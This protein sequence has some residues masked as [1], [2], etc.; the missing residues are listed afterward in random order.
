MGDEAGLE[1]LARGGA[2]GALT[3]WA[4]VFAIGPGRSSVR[5][6]AALLALAVI[7]FVLNENHTLAKNVG[8]IGRPLFVLSVAAVGYL[9]FLVRTLFD[10]RV[11]TFATTAPIAALTVSGLAGALAP[12]GLGKAIWPLHHALEI[13]FAVHAITIVTTT[14]RADLVE[15]RRRTR[16]AVVLAMPA[17]DRGYRV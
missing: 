1:M 13:I 16:G 12:G 3:V 15:L 8:P 2:M 4:I 14:W 9:W 7:G 17:D 6:A 5:T 11:V 10:D